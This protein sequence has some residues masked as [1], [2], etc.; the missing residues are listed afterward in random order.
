MSEHITHI[1]VYEDCSRMILNSKRFCEAFRTCIKNQYDSG[2]ITSGSRGNH[3]WAVPIFEKYREGW[4]Q[5]KQDKEIQEQIAG[6]IGWLTHRASDLQMKPLWRAM[7]KKDPSFN[8]SEMQIYHDAVTVKEVYEGG[9]RSTES[10]Y[11]LITPSTLEKGMVSHSASD[12]VNVSQVETLLAYMWQ[13]EFVELHQF[14]ADKEDADAYVDNFIDNHQPFTEDLRIYFEAFQKPDP[15]KMEEYI[16][17]FNHYD[18]EDEIIQYVRG[19]QRNLPYEHIDLE[20]AVKKAENQSQ[21]AQALRK[22]YVFLTS[23]NDFF[24]GILEKDKLYD[25]LDI[26]ENDRY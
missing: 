19:L 23:A 14:N 24:T 8:D 15:Q 18:P 17:S 16:Y 21:Y 1:A 11:E 13:R 2:M 5:G 22:G 25:V 9:K 7:V 10:P 26:G 3:L 12:S 4:D 6:A 20:M